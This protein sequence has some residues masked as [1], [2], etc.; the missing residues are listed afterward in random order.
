VKRPCA[1]E[2]MPQGDSTG[3]SHVYARGDLNPRELITANDWRSEAL[4]NP[5]D[6]IDLFRPIPAISSLRN[7]HIRRPHFPFFR[8][9]HARRRSECEIA[10]ERA[11]K[12]P[13][14]RARSALITTA[15]AAPSLLRTIPRG[16]PRPCASKSRLQFA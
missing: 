2:W 16:P 8:Q 4:H 7:R 14:A 13:S 9:G 5:I 6:Y 15:A 3:R 11:F 10:C 12:N 1:A